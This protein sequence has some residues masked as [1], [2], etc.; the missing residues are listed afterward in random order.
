MAKSANKPGQD[1]KDN[2]GEDWGEA[3]ADD[4]EMFSPAGEGSSPFFLEDEQEKLPEGAKNNRGGGKNHASIPQSDGL[5]KGLFGSKVFKKI[6]SLAWPVRIALAA[7]LLLAL[8]LLIMLLRPAPGPQKPAVPRQAVQQIQPRLPGE[9]PAAAG[10]RVTERAGQLNQAEPA[11]SAKKR[12]PQTAPPVSEPSEQMGF[13]LISGRRTRK[14]P[15]NSF[16]IAVPAAAD[17]KSVVLTVDLTLFV[18]LAK[19]AALPVSR[20][21]FLRDL[22]YQFFSNQPLADLQRFTL[23]RSVLKRRLMAWIKKQ[24]PGLSIISISF[25]RYQLL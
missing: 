16:F 7:A 19:K 2:I 11:V 20:E 22:I 4:D 13:G 23:A 10:S 1:N 21:I 12:P 14:W 24:W 6:I 3:F 15:L 5:L 18:Q 25:N 9:Q 17:H 8:F